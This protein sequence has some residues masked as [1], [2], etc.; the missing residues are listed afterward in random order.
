[1]YMKAAGD[2]DPSWGY[3]ALLLGRKWLS[4]V[5]PRLVYMERK[6]NVHTA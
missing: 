1:M 2:A 3:P 6:L 5:A 4:R